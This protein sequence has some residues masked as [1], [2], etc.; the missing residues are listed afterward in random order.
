MDAKKKQELTEGLNF[1]Y[2]VS[3]KSPVDK[4]H[5]DACLN[6]GTELMKLIESIEV[7]EE[8]QEAAP[9]EKV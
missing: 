8:S 3:T 2:N 6:I 4:P 9:L 7:K 5:H 1:L